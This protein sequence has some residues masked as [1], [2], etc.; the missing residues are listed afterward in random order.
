[1]KDKRAKR[2]SKIG[3]PGNNTGARMHALDHRGETSEKEIFSANGYAMYAEHKARPNDLIQLNIISFS[4]QISASGE[5]NLN[6]SDT[7]D[8]Y[9]NNGNFFAAFFTIDIKHFD[10]AFCD[11]ILTSP[12]IQF[13][14]TTFN[15]NVICSVIPQ[16]L[17]NLNTI[18]TDEQCSLFTKYLPAERVDG[19]RFSTAL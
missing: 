19:G 7:N 9:G 12:I 2:N 3:A 8:K 4:Y 17:L 18:N 15:V 10:S 14:F 5:N 16:Y 6:N 1:M 11:S 13:C